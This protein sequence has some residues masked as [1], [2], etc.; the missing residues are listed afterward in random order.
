MVWHLDTRTLRML[1][2]VAETT[3][4]VQAASRLNISPSALS[5]QMKSAEAT[6]RVALFDRRG[7]HL[8]LSATG[9]QL[10]AAA[11]RIVAEL[12]V[13]EDILER[14]RRGASGAVRV[15]GGAYPVQ[16]L[17]LERLA[18]DVI[19]GLHVVS[20]TKAFPLARAVLDGELDLALVGARVSA[21]G[22]AAV[23]LFAD[24]L[25]AVLPVGHAFAGLPCLSGQRFEGETY[26]SYSRVVEDGLED[27]LLFRPAR[28]APGRFMLAESVEAIL[29]LVAAGVGFGILS[30]WAVSEGSPGVTTIPLLPGGARVTWT[31]VKRE[32]ERSPAVSAVRDAIVHGLGQG[33][34]PGP[35]R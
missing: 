32:A 18:P 2:A 21:R 26:I 7:P 13:A 8:R 19:A 14:T 6:L 9:E 11:L 17:L 30:R 16:R 28:V 20:R 15:G 10:Y 1:I 25:V 35:G 3:T 23:P 33:G 4:G 12:E 31:L 29:D 34:P 5:H 22:L 24:D 27:E